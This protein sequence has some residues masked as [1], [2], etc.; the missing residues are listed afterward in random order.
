VSSVTDTTAGA[1]RA[2]PRRA[3]GFRTLLQ[4]EL[5]LFA[6]EPMLLFWGL[7]FPVGLL[8]VLGVAGPKKPEHAL[9]GV[10]F[11]IVYTPVVLMLMLTVLSLSAL[12]AA[13]V[14]YREKGYL[15]RLSTTPVGAPRLLAAQIVIDA[16]LVAATVLLILLVARFG[17]SVPLP[18]EVGGFLLAIGLTMAAMLAFGVL[19]AAAAP[20][21]RVA[22]GIGSLLLFP[23]MF[24]AGLWI[25]QTEMGA[26]LRDVSHYTPLGA[27]A[28][29]VQ[30]AIAGHWPGTVHLLVLAGY[31]VVLCALSVRFFRWE[32]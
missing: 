24:F 1:L 20:S 22:A 8:V 29:A 21:Q 18:Q 14:S 32:R 5:K 3:Y 13:L 31:A 9:G 11:I 6:R 12:P 2:R 17:F 19:I 15:R 28:P 10:K 4:T 30:S 25:P 27:A 7:V 26:G 23:L 16:A